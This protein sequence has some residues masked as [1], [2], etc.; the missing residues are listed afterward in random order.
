MATSVLTKNHR[1][2]YLAYETNSIENVSKM[3]NM[4]SIE[5]DFYWN[6]KT[7]IGIL[8][9]A[10][11]NKSLYLFHYS[12]SIESDNSW[13]EQLLH[14]LKTVCQWLTFSSSLIDLEYSKYSDSIVF[15]CI[16][17]SH[18]FEQTIL[19]QLIIDRNLLQLKYN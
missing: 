9:A 1:I 18:I 15:I 4:L 5:F 8:F 16:V 19:V 3:V 13:H 14:V 12:K 10:H 2:L 11:Q 17:F 7:V 6:L